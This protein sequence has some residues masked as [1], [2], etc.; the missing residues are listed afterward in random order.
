MSAVMS[1]K[2]ETI[3]APP[4]RDRAWHVEYQLENW[5][6]WMGSGRSVDKL[7][8]RASGGA[9]NASSLDWDNC[10]SSY[11]AMD[12]RLAATCNAVINSLDPVEG[13]ALI[14]EYLHAVFRFNRHN[15][16]EVLAR[17]K[18]SLARGLI[19]KG[20]WLG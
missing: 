13:A 1:E 15:F 5:A 4:I 6:R 19:G 10:V 16:D 17:A 7:P 14:T 2:S 9:E 18:V 8:T 12:I 3:V 11:E 20:V